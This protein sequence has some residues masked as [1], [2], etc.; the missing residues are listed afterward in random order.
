MLTVW[1]H[2]HE[3]EKARTGSIR[4]LPVWAFIALRTA[5]REQFLIQFSLTVQSRRPDGKTMTCRHVS[6]D[7]A[8]R[9]KRSTH[10]DECFKPSFC[11]SGRPGSKNTIQVFV[12]LSEESH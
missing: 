1:K 5:H 6:K 2:R 11:S 3:T 8:I 9:F 10:Q 12:P 7:V 4:K